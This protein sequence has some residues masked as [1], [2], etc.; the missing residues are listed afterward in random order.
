MVRASTTPAESRTTTTAP[1][2]GIPVALSRTVPARA[3]V[4]PC[5]LAETANVADKSATPYAVR[6]FIRRPFSPGFDP[7]MLSAPLDFQKKRTVFDL[8][9]QDLHQATAG[10]RPGHRLPRPRWPPHFERSGVV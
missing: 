10:N 7:N 8:W 3:A 4:A 9:L 5:A 1:D 6:A 2:K